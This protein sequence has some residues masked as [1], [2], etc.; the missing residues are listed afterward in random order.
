[1][2]W[3]EWGS[4]PEGRRYTVLGIEGFNYIET[5]D[6]GIEVTNPVPPARFTFAGGFGDVPDDLIAEQQFGDL[7][8]ELMNAVWLNVEPTQDMLMPNTV[9]EGNTDFLPNQATMYREI[10][11]Q[12]ITGQVA[13][14]QANWDAYVEDWYAAGG[15]TV[16][17]RATEWYREFYGE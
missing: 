12:M 10:I 11:G 6:G 7:K 15:Q 14:T 2:E 17:D 3:V 9:Y 4:S 1:M 16:T 8:V 13:P 5:E